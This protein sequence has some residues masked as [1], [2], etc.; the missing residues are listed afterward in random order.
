MAIDPGQVELDGR[1]R[2]ADVVVDLTGH[3]GTRQLDLGLQV[4]GQL[5]Q[6]LLGAQQLGVRAPRALDSAASTACCN[7]GARRARLFLSR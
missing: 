6:T 2:A 7:A 4:A 3:A 1:Q 5:V